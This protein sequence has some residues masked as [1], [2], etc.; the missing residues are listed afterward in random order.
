[1][2]VIFFILNAIKSFAIH[3]N[4]PLEFPL[5]KDIDFEYRA[6][7]RKLGIE[8]TCEKSKNMTSK[9]RSISEPYFTRY[10]YNKYVFVAFNT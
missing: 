8:E 7:T 1:M 3:Y 9:S 10:E 5:L 4:D 2:R 6:S